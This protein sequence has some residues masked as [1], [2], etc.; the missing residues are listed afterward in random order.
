[1]GEKKLGFEIHITKYSG[2]LVVETEMGNNTTI[3]QQYYT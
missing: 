2:Y 3:L 1:M